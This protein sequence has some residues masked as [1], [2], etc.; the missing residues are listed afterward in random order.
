MRRMKRKD[1]K[2]KE[3]LSNWGGRIKIRSQG[4]REGSL[5]MIRSGNTGRKLKD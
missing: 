4:I 5:K 2:I 3:G 1:A